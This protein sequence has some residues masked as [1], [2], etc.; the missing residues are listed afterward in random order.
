V[1]TRYSQ[2]PERGAGK[3]NV[4][5]FQFTVVFPKWLSSDDKEH[6]V[7][8]EDRFRPLSLIYADHRRR[9]RLRVR[10]AIRKGVLTDHSQQGR[11]RTE[12]VTANSTRSQSPRQRSRPTRRSVIC[13]K[14]THKAAENP[15]W[16]PRGS[17]RTVYPGYLAKMARTARNASTALNPAAKNGCGKM[18]PVTFGRITSRQSRKFK[19]FSGR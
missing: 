18:K 13:P 7:L 3:R 12:A 17:R 9:R 4:P 15:R 1:K 16:H 11:R 8:V 10:R 5:C 14:D 2:S 19:N 6:S